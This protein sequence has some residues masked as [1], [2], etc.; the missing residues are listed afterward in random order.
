MPDDDTWIKKYFL[1][2]SVGKHKKTTYENLI[3]KLKRISIHLKKKL[4]IPSEPFLIGTR[5]SSKY[6]VKKQHWCFSQIILI[7]AKEEDAEGVKAT[8]KSSQIEGIDTYA[9]LE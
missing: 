5:I 3:T 8:F 6:L 1:V 4:I 2:K 9:N 7:Y